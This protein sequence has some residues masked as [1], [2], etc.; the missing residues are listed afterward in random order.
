MTPAESV[1]LFRANVK[2]LW[3]KSPWQPLLTIWFSSDLETIFVEDCKRAG[4]VPAETAPLVLNTLRWCW[5]RSCL[6]HADDP[7]WQRALT[8]ARKRQARVGAVPEGYAYVPPSRE[9][10]DDTRIK[11]VAR[12]ATAWEPASINPVVDRSTKARQRRQKAQERRPSRRKIDLA[13]FIAEHAEILN[14]AFW[15]C[16]LDPGDVDAPLGRQL[17]LA[18]HAVITEQARLG[19]ASYGP[20]RKVW[21]RLLRELQS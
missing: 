3:A 10:P 11:R 13:L 8:A 21:H 12:R 14:P 15:T 7:A 9:P 2:A 1:R 16:N 19:D 18:W 17:A 5:R 20:A 6:N 4:L